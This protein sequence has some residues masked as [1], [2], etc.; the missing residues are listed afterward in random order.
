MYS[1]LRRVVVDGLAADDNA[2]DDNDA[3][4]GGGVGCVCVKIQKVSEQKLLNIRV[5]KKRI[6]QCHCNIRFMQESR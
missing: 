5:E 2:D 6:G 4:G 3:G 1:L